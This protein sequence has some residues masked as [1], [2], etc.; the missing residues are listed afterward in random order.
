MGDPAHG[1]PGHDCPLDKDYTVVLAGI[2]LVAIED[3]LEEGLRQAVSRL[4]RE[5]DRMMI[6]EVTDVARG[7]EITAFRIEAFT[8]ALLRI[9]EQIDKIEDHEPTV[10]KSA[11][12]LR[13]EEFRG[14]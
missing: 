8:Q 11:E 14:A 9:Q 6:G 7:V 12:Q 13:E 2:N 1:E 10:P 3:A 5:L 4:G